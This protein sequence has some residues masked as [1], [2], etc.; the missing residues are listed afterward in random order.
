MKTKK[1]AFILFA[2]LLCNLM[3]AFPC[4][5]TGITVPTKDKYSASDLRYLT[6][7]IYCEARGEGYAGQK[8]VGI[9]VMN[10]VESELFPND[11]V[12]VIYQ[13]GQFSPVGNGSLSSALS[14]YDRQKESGE[15]DRTMLSCFQAAEEVLEGSREVLVNE[16]GQDFS[17]YL[18]FSRYISGARYQLGHHMFR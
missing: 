13:S 1:I 6:S 5:A 17:D 15:W 7:I 18:F 14:Q 8:A 11:V 10:R 2:V 9:V 12:D 3:F 16:S 4:E